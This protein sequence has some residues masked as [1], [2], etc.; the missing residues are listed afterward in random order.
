[1]NPSE[2]WEFSDFLADGVRSSDLLDRDGWFVRGQSPEALYISHEEL[3]RDGFGGVYVNWVKNGSNYLVVLE[4]ATIAP[5]QIQVLYKDDKPL[6]DLT[7]EFKERA[8]RQVVTVLRRSILEKKEGLEPAAMD[9]LNTVREASHESAMNRMDGTVSETEAR[10]Q[11]DRIRRAYPGLAIG[12]LR[13]PTW[14][15][16]VLVVDH[17]NTRR[18]SVISKYTF[19]IIVRETG[20][21]ISKCLDLS[22]EI[23]ETPNSNDR[24]K[25]YT[26]SGPEEGID[27]LMDFGYSPV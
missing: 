4:R 20:H 21:F 8:L 6:E 25:E 24:V 15:R 3:E 19:R 13:V 17:K 5:R 27:S 10:W 14:D 1:M 16:Y 18:A 22:L 26:V 11:S 2:L 12:V 7:E 23:V 9:D